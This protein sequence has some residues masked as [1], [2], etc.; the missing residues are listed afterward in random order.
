MRAPQIS[1]VDTDDGMSMQI[2][3]SG[4]K[5]DPHT[6][7]AYTYEWGWGVGGGVGDVER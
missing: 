1:L 6:Q 4:D 5:A 7:L 2:E 3:I